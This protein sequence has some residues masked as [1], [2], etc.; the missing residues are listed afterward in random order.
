MRESAVTLIALAAAALAPAQPPSPTFPSRIELIT[1]D[2]VVV[3]KKGQPVTGLTRD[4]FVLEEDGRAQ[5]IVSFEAVRLEAPAAEATPAAAV[6]ATN[7]VEKARP[8]RAFAIVLDDL[9]NGAGRR[10]GDE[11]RRG[12]RSSS[13]RCRTATR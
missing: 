6:V 13:G 2:V 1:V 9:G 3:D 12:R 11:A 7:E 5:P 4:D 8:G 10:R